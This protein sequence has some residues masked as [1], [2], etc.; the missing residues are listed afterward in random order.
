MKDRTYRLLCSVLRLML[1]TPGLGGLSVTGARALLRQARWVTF[2]RRMQFDGVVDGGANIGEFAHLVRLALPK[3]DL[4][5]VEPLAAPARA[6]RGAGFRVEEAALWDEEGTL[7]LS[8][9]GPSSTSATVMDPSQGVPVRAVRLDGLAVAG[10]RLLIKLDLQGAE[11]HA[12]RGIGDLLPRTAGFLLEVSFGPGG[13]YASLAALMAG[14]GFH[15]Y[16]TLNECEDDDRVVEADKVFLRTAV[17]SELG[18]A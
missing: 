1:R 15:E 4:V 17:L 12:L 2:L 11:L 18:L 3:A 5:C 13:T 6:L 10:R 14:W 8:V 9:P 16:A 7:S